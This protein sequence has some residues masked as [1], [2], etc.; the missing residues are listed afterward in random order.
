MSPYNKHQNFA[1]RGWKDTKQKSNSLL[2]YSGAPKKCWLLVLQYV[3][4]VLNHVAM[5]SLGWRTPVEWLI[6]TTP[7]ISNLLQFI[8]WEPV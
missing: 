5:A 1:E 8:F 2:N 3:C 4:F 7:D 6:G